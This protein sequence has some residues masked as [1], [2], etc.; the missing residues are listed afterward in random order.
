MQSNKDDLVIRFTNG[1]VAA[2][3]EIF[4]QFHHRI[5]VFCKYLVPDE[6]AKD[7]TADIFTRLWKLRKDLDSIHNIRAFLFISARN[8]SFNRIRDL[9]ARTEREK[10]IAGFMAKEEKLIILSE[11]E[12][13]IITRIKEEVDKLPENCRQVF[14][15]AYFE[16]Y[17]ITEIAEKLSLSEK[18]VSNL[19]SLALKAIKTVFLNKNNMQLGVFVLLY[20]NY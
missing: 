12:S 19:K 6:D 17:K 8:A 9:K 14:T 16:G 2:Y 1:E 4:K 10:E 3:N 11:T 7:I 18:T 20:F 5:Y 15:L 13:D